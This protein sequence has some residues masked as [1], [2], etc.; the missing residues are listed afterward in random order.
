MSVLATFSL[1]VMV[2]ALA[3]QHAEGA[4]SLDPSTSVSVVPLLVVAAAVVAGSL[5]CYAILQIAKSESTAIE[6]A[7]HD[8]LSGLPNRAFFNQLIDSEIAAVK[9]QGG[10]FALLYLDLD[11]F[12]EINDS[13]GHDAGDRIIVAAAQRMRQVTRTQ[14]IVARLAGDEFAVLQTAVTGTRDCELLARRIL[15]AVN[16]IYDLD[17]RHVHLGVS[18]GIALCPQDTLDRQELMRRADLALYRAKKQGRNRPAFFEARMGEELRL[19]KNAE[20]ELR[21]AIDAERL[22]LLYQPVVNTETRRLVA[23]EALVRWQHPTRGMVQP[24]DFIGLAEDR[25]LILP[26]GEWVLRRACTEA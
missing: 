6:M 23:V 4:L 25:G 19:R 1:V 18:I 12:K 26:L 16:E 15:K 8:R 11:R 10:G 3:A 9:R 5:C 14:D 2:L 21:Q 20:D 13:L 7:S 17:G 24:D 22:T